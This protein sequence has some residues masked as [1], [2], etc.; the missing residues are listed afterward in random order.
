MEVAPLPSTYETPKEH[1]LESFEI[2]Q[3]ENIYKLNI[4][5]INKDIFNVKFMSRIFR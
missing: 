2:K 3:D 5:I 1:I 4:E